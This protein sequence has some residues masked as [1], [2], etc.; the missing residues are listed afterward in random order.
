MRKTLAGN[1]KSMPNQENKFVNSETNP[2]AAVCCPFCG[3]AET[4][5]E[6][7]FGTT[8]AYAQFYCCACHTPFEWIKWEN[9]EKAQAQ[10]L[11][12]IF[13]ADKISGKA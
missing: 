1:V 12:A 8:L 6:S 7:D 5:R 10:D 4:R 3:S 11:P 2:N 9:Q 13:V